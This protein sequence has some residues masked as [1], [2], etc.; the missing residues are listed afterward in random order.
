M[1]HN[2]WNF[3][4]EVIGDSMFLYECLCWCCAFVILCK[5]S[6][7]VGTFKR[8]D[9]ETVSE[10]DFEVDIVKAWSDLDKSL[11][12]EGLISGMDYI[13]PV[14]YTIINFEKCEKTK[15]STLHFDISLATNK[16]WN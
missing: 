5:T 6:F 10:E 7:A 13:W 12:A 15:V 14:L 8:P 3:I 11:I 16:S 4:C 2:F 1:F 9:P